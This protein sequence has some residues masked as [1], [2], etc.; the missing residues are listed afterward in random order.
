M[1][2]QTNFS[3]QS[4]AF[5]IIVS[6]FLASLLN[7]CAI[8]PSTIVETPTTAKPLAP[9][10]PSNAN[11]AIYSASSHRALF[12]DRRARAVGDILTINITENTTANKAGSSASSKSGSV[13]SSASI[14]G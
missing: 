10:H 2:T 11:G 9:K 8:T 3:T 1:L 13:S 12:E 6:M 5:R 7:A 4:L 14:P